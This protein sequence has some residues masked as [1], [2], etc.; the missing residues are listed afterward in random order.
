[1]AAPGPSFPKRGGSGHIKPKWGF[2]ASGEMGSV[3]CLRSSNPATPMF[4]M[5]NTQTR[6]VDRNE[7]SA[8][9][10]IGHVMSSIM[11]WRRGKLLSNWD[12]TKAQSLQTAGSLPMTQLRLR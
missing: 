8:Q 7:G 12:C 4:Q 3:V 1:V 2:F 9:L 10:E 6:R 11:R 5:G